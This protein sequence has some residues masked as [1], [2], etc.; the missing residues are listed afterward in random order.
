MEREGRKRPG[1]GTKRAP[2][3]NSI[4][5][6]KKGGRGKSARI[7]RKLRFPIGPRGHFT[8]DRR[9][10]LSHLQS[11]DGIKFVARLWIYIEFKAKVSS[12]G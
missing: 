6:K 10:P 2:P 7:T 9:S 8:N 5:L 4:L 3:R 12:N 1:V 11:S